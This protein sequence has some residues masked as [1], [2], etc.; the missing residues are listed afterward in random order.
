MMYRIATMLLPCYLI[1]GVCIGSSC[2]TIADGSVIASS[3]WDC[4]CDPNT[5]DTLIIRN[6]LVFDTDLLI[7]NPYLVVTATGSLAGTGIG[8]LVITG[9]ISN[10]GSITGT[11]VRFFDQGKLTNTGTVAAGVL[12][13]V[14]DSTLNYG[15]MTGTDS[16]VLGYARR[17]RN[18]GNLN[19][20]VFYSLGFYENHGSTAA[21]SIASANWYYTNIGSTTANSFVS[22]SFDSWPSGTMAVSGKM[23]CGSFD[24]SGSVIADS[25]IIQGGWLLDGS[26][27]CRSA[28]VIE[29]PSS[30]FSI[31]LTSG[32]I[33]G[34]IITRDLL[35]QEGVSLFGPGPICISGHSENH[36]HF[37]HILDVCDLSRTTAAPPFLDVNTGTWHPSVTFCTN[38]SCEGVGITEP[39]DQGA[40]RVYPQPIEGSFI[41]ELPS[42]LSGPLTVEVHDM[43][44]RTTRRGAYSSA[45]FLQLERGNETA[46][47][48]IL[49]VSAPRGNLIQERILFGQ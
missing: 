4:G 28:L 1:S 43:M 15:S 38:T 17:M 29:A 48:H 18:Y 5:C 24:N 16:L 41:V 49:I 42:A 30:P 23:F 32:G 12:I 35:I 10:E 40:L 2:T 19:A 46:G 7:A 14:K 44:G 11:Y 20:D 8:Q 13:T 9:T 36:G 26:T 34:S 31:H 22:R 33:N 6:A 27:V 25:L 37:G 39:L 3:V 45:E 47:I 21:T